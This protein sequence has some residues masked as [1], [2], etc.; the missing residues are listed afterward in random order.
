[1]TMTLIDAG[2]NLCNAQFDK[3]REA[4]L[5]R[6]K[7]ANISNLLLIGTELAQSKQALEDANRYGFFFNRR[8]SSP[9]R[10]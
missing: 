2:V 1:M 5:A 3:D 10:C 7:A 8:H 4:V 6:A 9:L